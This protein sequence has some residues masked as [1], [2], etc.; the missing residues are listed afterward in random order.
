MGP[1]LRA[2]LV[3]ALGGVLLVVVG[4]VLASTAGLLF[5]AG[6]T[7][8]AGGLVLAGAA[9][10]R[11]EAAPVNRRT[12]V[13]LAIGLVVLS[14]VLASLATWL[15]ARAEGGVLDP[16]EYLWTT[17]GLFV[18]GELVLGA[19]GAAWGASAGPVR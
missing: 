5:V 9:A 6:A 3:A 11:D 4:A 12:V 2:T 14:V 10:P 18:P 13:W 1:L 17:F 15:V 16:L 19:V 8:A 7:G